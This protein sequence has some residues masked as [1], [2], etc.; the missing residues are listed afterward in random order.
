MNEP[1]FTDLVLLI[2]NERM[3]NKMNVTIVEEREWNREDKMRALQKLREDIG[4]NAFRMATAKV[5]AIGIYEDMYWRGKR[6]KISDIH[7]MVNVSLRGYGCEEV[8]YATIQQLLN[9][10]KIVVK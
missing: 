7:L 4:D 2:I 5:Q 8:S 10:H 1:E 3:G 6:M 9:N